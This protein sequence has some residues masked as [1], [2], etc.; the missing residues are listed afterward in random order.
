MFYPKKSRC[1]G[2]RNGN[3]RFSSVPREALQMQA[4]KSILQPCP[5]T[6]SEAGKEMGRHPTPAGILS[7]EFPMQY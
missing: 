7:V 1:Q 5:R 3:E 2:S 6:Y 4:T